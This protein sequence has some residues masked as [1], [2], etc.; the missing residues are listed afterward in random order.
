MIEISLIKVV[1]SWLVSFLIGFLI[2]PYVIKVLTRFRCWKKRSGN[3]HSMGSNGGTP[4]FNKLH[5]DRDTRVP[6]MGGIV[7]VI[8]V[9]ATTSIFWAI[10][11]IISGG[12]SGGDF[13]FLSRTQ[14]WLPLAAF[15]AGALIGFIDD[16]LTIGASRRF[17][18]LQGLALRYRIILSTAF[19]IL[20]AYWFYVKLGIDSVFVPWYGDFVMGWWFVPFFILAF[21]AIFATS[22]IDGLD[23]LAGG[24]M[25]I[26]FTAM[27]IIAYFQNQIDIAAFC[28][29]IVGGTLAFL[30]F[31]IPPARF[32]MTE[33]GYNALSFSLAIVA[34]A[35]DTILILPVLAVVLFMTE[36]TTILQV[37]SK[38]IRGKK[39]FRVAPIHHHFEAIGWPAHQVVMRYWIVSLIGAV[40][41]VMLAFTA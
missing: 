7:I 9:L 13:D 37:L 6:R 10:G 4:I 1:L 5:A 12:P 33:V 34:F 2:T 18:S 8:S 24:V 31:N 26:I 36:I 40:L 30:W 32:Y 35:T 19:A 14:T 20:S 27:G 16:L 21:I 41:G 28:F 11:F 17:P 38:K 39:I 29:A 15:V 23:G 25:A 22:N 3:T